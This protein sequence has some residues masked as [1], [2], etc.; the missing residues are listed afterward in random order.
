MEQFHSIVGFI[1]TFTLRESLQP[2]MTEVLQLLRQLRWAKTILLPSPLLVPPLGLFKSFVGL[3]FF[4]S[5]FILFLALGAV[6]I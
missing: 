4:G 6:S 2:Q 1:F 3:V 5:I